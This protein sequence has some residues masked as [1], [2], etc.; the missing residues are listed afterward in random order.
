MKANLDENMSECRATCSYKTAGTRR[1][2]EIALA[3]I[4]RPNVES[5]SDSV[6]PTRS[7][8]KY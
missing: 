3:S 4:Q 1:R 7:E 8:F 5:M 6:I 2:N